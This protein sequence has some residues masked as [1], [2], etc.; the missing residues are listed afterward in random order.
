M[1]KARV[2]RFTALST[3]ASRTTFAQVSISCFISAVSSSGVPVLAA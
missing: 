1:I 2:R 3:L